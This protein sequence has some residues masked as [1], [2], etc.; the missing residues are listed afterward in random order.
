MP[1]SRENEGK[2]VENNIRVKNIWVKIFRENNR[3]YCYDVGSN[4]LLE[5]EE[6]L[7]DVLQIYNY[8]N[9][10][11]VMGSLAGKYPEKRIR[12]ALRT[13]HDYNGES[14]GFIPVKPVRLHFPFTKDQ[15]RL[16]LHNLVNHVVLN[17]TE[18]C[19]FRCVYCQYG[20]TYPYARPH[21]PR[22]MPM[23]RIRTAIDFMV[24]RA[25]HIIRKTDRNLSVGF[26]GG[27]PLLEKDKIFGAVEYI[28]N[29][30]RDIFPRF[31][32]NMTVNGSL[33]DRDTIQ[34]LVDYDFSLVI[35]LDGPR[36]THDRYRVFKDRRETFDV[37]KKKIDLIK[38]MAPEYFK[39]KVK[40]NVV[41]AP[42]FKIKDVIDFFRKNYPGAG[43][44]FSPVS[45]HDTAFFDNFNMRREYGQYDRE[46]KEIQKE[47]ID[48]KVAGTG[49]RFLDSLFDANLLEIHRRLQFPLPDI[50]FPNGICLPGLKR[51]FVDVDGGIHMCEKINPGFAIGTIRDGFDFDAI[52]RH[53]HRYIET[54]NHCDGCWAVRF[55]SECFL[56]SIKGDAFSKERKEKNCMLRREKLLADFRTYTRLMQKAPASLDN[57]T[58]TSL[59]DMLAV[60]LDFLEK[61]H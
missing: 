4:S 10:P 47:Y 39:N 12:E 30:Y 11:E 43:C 28:R 15:Y 3:T 42:E 35:S 7:A 13:I 53:I 14:G 5:I 49:D 59:P 19:N 57:V 44:T 54:A 36:D 48:R 25:D 27:E 52:F 37:V 55:C 9:E 45:P 40:F 21:T 22:S 31:S 8:S 23:G 41:T 24:S 60:A 58:V 17:I 32:F 46:F 34:R 38:W 61:N 26:Y 29:T 2:L 1:T 51:I 16:L 50:V 18:D 33:L 20:E 56:S 6:T